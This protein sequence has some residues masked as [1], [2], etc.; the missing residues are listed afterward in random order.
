MRRWAGQIWRPDGRAALGLAGAVRPGP[1]AAMLTASAVL[2]AAG[3]SAAPAVPYRA[4]ASTCYAFAVR[5]IQRHVTVT[6][7]PGACAGL[8]HEQVN[9]AA[10]RAI[11]DLTEGQ[12]KAAA[13][14]LARRDGGYLARMVSVIPA[15]RPPAPAA[16]ATAP[17][18]VP[19]RP[20]AGLPLGLAALAAWVLT[21]AAG[22][23]LLA[24]WLADRL[25]GARR[26]RTW[27]RTDRPAGRPGPRRWR[28]GPGRW[29]PGPGRWRPGPG[30]RAGEPGAGFIVGHFGLALGG[31]VVWVA[32]VVTGLAALAWIAVVLVVIIASL[33]MAVLAA[34]LPEPSRDTAAAGRRRLPVAIIA[35]HGVLATLTILLVVLAALR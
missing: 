12:P 32:F 27:R 3:C 7:A 18:P 35:S 30:S 4:T 24:G 20:A 33:G 15:P 16:Q 23:Y 9:Q 11:R 10:A 8:S 17:V 22:T 31:L 28:P 26:P 1:L 14:R 34:A 25:A 21:A 19:A 2:L 29:R 13:R 6:A 5:A